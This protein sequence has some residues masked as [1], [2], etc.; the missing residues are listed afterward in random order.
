MITALQVVIS[1]FFLATGALKLT[2]S[3]GPDAKIFPKLGVRLSW[4]R[5]LGWV[6]LMIAA[7]L[8]IGLWWNAFAL[9]AACLASAY[10]GLA[11]TLALRA[12]PAQ[13]GDA[14]QVTPVLLLC[15]SLVLLRLQ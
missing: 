5:P 11:L 8:L 12:K 6:Q 13:L 4:L 2:P 9:P 15:L 1:L 7:G 3:G 14:A 10:F